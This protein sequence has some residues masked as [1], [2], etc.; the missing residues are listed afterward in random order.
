MPRDV[1][2]ARIEARVDA[3][4][5]AGLVDEVAALERQGLREGR[6]AS[7]ALGYRQV[8]AHLAGECTE[9][10]ARDATV[11]GTRTLRP[12][13]AVMVRTGPAHP[14]AAVRRSRTWWIGRSPSCTQ[15]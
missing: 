6:T 7:R 3:M 11:R 15:M 13:P 4:W 2:D 14:L 5:A 10:Q 12:P 8:L 9:Q 1:L